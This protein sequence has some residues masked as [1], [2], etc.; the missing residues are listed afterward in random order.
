[1]RIAI[2]GSGSSGNSILIESDDTKLLIDAGYSGKKIKERMDILNRDLNDIDGI[3]VTHEHGDH[4][5]GVGILSRRY[6]LPIYITR[7]SYF[8][9][10]EKL[11]KISDENLK[12]IDDENFKIKN[13]DITPFDVMHDAERTLG[14]RVENRWKGKA[15]G[16][17]TDIGYATNIV[18]E[19]LKNLDALVIE[20]NYDYNMLMTCKY[21]WPL[22]SR[23]KSNNGHLSNEDALKLVNEVYCDKLKKVYF[24][25]V[26][27]D[28]NCYK[29][30][31][32]NVIETLKEFNI[33]LDYELI[34]QETVSEFYNI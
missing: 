25:H 14:F 3:V 31:E 33:E 5:M 27:R 13:L 7:E 32:A 29:L 30:A 20:S 9:A 19:K 18:K 16:V 34:R 2:L 28:S 23:V 1:M 22:K 10:E 11:G 6:N 15:V 21:P 26:S 8:A 12:F 24:V 4:I 17:A